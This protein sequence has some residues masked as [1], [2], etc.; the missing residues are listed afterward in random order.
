MGIGYL[1]Q[2]LPLSLAGN[3]PR[4]VKA[5]DTILPECGRVLF[6]PARSASKKDGLAR[7]LSGMGAD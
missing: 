4:C 1:L 5:A 3:Y 2:R 7:F 6:Y